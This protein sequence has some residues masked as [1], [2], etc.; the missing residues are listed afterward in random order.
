MRARCIGKVE[1]RVFWLL[2]LPSS[3]KARTREGASYVIQDIRW[4]HVGFWLLMPSAQR[5]PL[6]PARCHSP[7]PSRIIDLVLSTSPRSF[8]R[9]D[10]VRLE[11]QR[12]LFQRQPQ[13]ASALLPFVLLVVLP[14]TSHDR[15]HPCRTMPHALY[16]RTSA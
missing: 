1:R 14:A 8:A 9:E 2:L 3:V 5:L 16:Y 12:S 6:S 7:N 11:R 13:E 4:R 10:D 15:V